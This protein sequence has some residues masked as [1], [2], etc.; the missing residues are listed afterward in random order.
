MGF[1]FTTATKEKARARIA[2]VGPAGAGKTFTALTV[3]KEF[4]GP[5][6]VID[7]ERGSASKYSGS[8]GFAFETLS[9]NNFDPR[10]FP[11]LM[12]AAAKVAGDG[13]LIIDSF[14][15]W[16]EGP[17]G[18]I[19]LVDSISSQ[20]RSGNSFQAWGKA[21]PIEKAMIDSLLAFPG[22]VI[23]TMRSKTEYVIEEDERGKKAPKKLGTAPIQR[24]GVE[25]EFDI[26]G[27]M[28]VD[29]AMLISKS[30][31]SEIR[32]VG[33]FKRP[34]GN[35]ARMVLAWLND[36]VEKKKEETRKAETVAAPPEP[37]APPPTTIESKIETLVVT[38]DGEVLEKGPSPYATTK[39]SQGAKMGTLIKEAGTKTRIAYLGKYPDTKGEERDAIN[40]WNEP[41]PFD[42]DP[43]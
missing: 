41:T 18:I 32:D 19:E 21:K 1:E 20:S 4:G 2:L 9:L 28:T 6:A 7:T 42:L 15:S 23:V 35:F 17:G 8:K 22:H 11:E 13:T 25:Y 24:A 34:N 40:Y 37:E 26:V 5:I 31:C 43:K 39:F 38:D 16:W 29:N 12:R 33:V 27:D 14:S 30:R 36:G 3:A 10:K